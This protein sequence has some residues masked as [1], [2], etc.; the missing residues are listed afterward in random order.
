M[1]CLD[2]NLI[3]NFSYPMSIEKF[4]GDKIEKRLY[5][6]RTF[7]GTED[8]YIKALEESSTL[9][10]TN[11]PFYIKE[12]RLWHMFGICGEV[13]R[14]IMG[15]NKNKKTAAEFAFV[16]FYNK[17]DALKAVDL[18]R[19][20]PLAGRTLAIDKDIGYSEGREVGRG[21]F[22]GKLKSDNFKRTNSLRN[23]YY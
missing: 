3:L 4:F 23:N 5:I 18:Y 22:G 12:E 1:K 8:E 14:I 6:E 17:E 11:I 13:R 10:I 15:I 16:E 2:L 20:F 19:G 21:V 7:K 9:Y